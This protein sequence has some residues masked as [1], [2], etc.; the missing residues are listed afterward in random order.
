[1]ISLALFV[2][3]VIVFVIAFIVFSKAED[4]DYHRVIQNRKIDVMRLDSNTKNI[5]KILE[6]LDRME[7]AYESNLIEIDREI[8]VIREKSDEV[9]E[10]Y[11][12]I[13]EK[14]FMVKPKRIRHKKNVV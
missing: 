1:M 13:L 8:D 10:K 3:S 7:K 5:E 4:T 2:G 12:V 6:R 14:L 9:K 11:Y